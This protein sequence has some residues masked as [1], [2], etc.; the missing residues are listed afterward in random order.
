MAGSHNVARRLPS[1]SRLP[2]FDLGL[3]PYGPLQALQG[4]LRQAVAEGSL[5]GVLLLLEHEP[6]ITL[7][8]RGT[9]G[10]LR[11]DARSNS[12][13]GLERDPRRVSDRDPEPGLLA[14]AKPDTG[15]GISS[16]SAA[17][18]V[19]RSE[20]GGQATLH[21]PGQLVSYP[22]VPVPGRDLGRYVHDLEECLIAV[23]A[24]YAINAER[25][26]RHPGLYVRGEKIASVGLRC[27][28]W[29][30]SHGTSL[31]VDVDL[32]L[33]ESIVSCGEAELRQ[34]SMQSLLGASPGMSDIKEA[35]C[36]AVDDVF[37]WRLAPMRQLAFSHVEGE[38]GL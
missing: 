35:Y 34:T 4:R 12:G 30:A 13:P 36:R 1:E 19:F 9:D 37:G 23:L 7:G 31:N 22:V 5:P 24:G 3:A 18:P 8:S 11:L 25:R 26:T 14:M 27:Q 32:T 10:D 2:V 28:R 6:V 20:R 16:V 38:L 33:F 29:V 15:P 17:I 21:A